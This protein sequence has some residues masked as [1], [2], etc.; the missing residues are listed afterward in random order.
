M[1]HKRFRRLLAWTRHWG[2]ACD[3]IV[4]DGGNDSQAHGSLWGWGPGRPFLLRPP[5][6]LFLRRG[7]TQ[8]RARQVAECPVAGTARPRG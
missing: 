2:F 8:S 4:A 1:Y 6:K 7:G 3:I 5:R